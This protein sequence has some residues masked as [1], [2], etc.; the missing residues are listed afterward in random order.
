MHNKNDLQ[1]NKHT[2]RPVCGDTAPNGIVKEIF[3][4][5]MTIKSNKCILNAGWYIYLTEYFP[6][7]TYFKNSIFI[8]HN[9]RWP[10]AGLCKL[11][12][13][14]LFCIGFGCYNSCHQLLQKAPLCGGKPW[15]ETSAN[16]GA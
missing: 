9:C 4:H 16:Q 1:I 12:T 13:L 3:V 7:V 15:V 6:Y 5:N 10:C 8:G 2:T 14:C 11:T